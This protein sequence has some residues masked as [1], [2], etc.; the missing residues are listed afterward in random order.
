MI[1]ERHGWVNSKS[2]TLEEVALRYGLSTSL[3]V[4]M[5]GLTELDGMV[6]F[7]SEALN[8]GFSE[9]TFGVMYRESSCKHS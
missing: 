5:D 3:S 9:L 8:I 1:S 2:V 7:V 6:L 4:S